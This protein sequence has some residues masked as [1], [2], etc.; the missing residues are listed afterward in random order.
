MA[1]LVS[2]LIPAPVGA[3]ISD[4][5]EFP[6]KERTFDSAF[7]FGKEYTDRLTL[8]SWNRLR[9]GKA[10]FQGDLTIIFSQDVNQKK[11]TFTTELISPS[12][13]IIPL[14]LKSEYVS[15]SEFSLYCY[16]N[17]CQSVM[18]TYGADLPIE[19][20]VGKYS[21][22]FTARWLGVKCVGTVCES[23]VPLS[24]SI[25]AKSALE[26]LGETTSTPTPTPAST[27]IS[28][29]TITCVKGKIVKKITA[30]K[31]Q[32]PTGYKKR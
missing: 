23:G 8:A 5:I 15:K 17:Y 27:A 11:Y 13:R 24:K 12:G 20:E 3:N 2:L 16:G 22:R 14:T 31:P 30:L 26:I 18:F 29:K 19:S 32:C 21:L 25:E 28:K 1:L 6:Y 9:S 7:Q 10:P 4:S